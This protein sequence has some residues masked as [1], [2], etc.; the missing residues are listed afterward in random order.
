MSDD[1][2]EPKLLYTDPTLEEAQEWVNDNPG[3]GVSGFACFY[4]G[5]YSEAA[6]LVRK[7]LRQVEEDKEDD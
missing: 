4:P 7:V 2:R 6:E 1:L 3:C 5:R